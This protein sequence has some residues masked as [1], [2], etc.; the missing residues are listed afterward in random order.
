MAKLFSFA[1][2]N[3]EHFNGNTN[4]VKR[5]VTF[6]KDAGPDVFAIFEVEGKYV[7][8]DFVTQMPAY[9]FFITEDRSR[10]ETLIG[11]RG[12]KTAFVTQ[13]QVFKSSIP[14]LRPGALASLRI[15]NTNYAV[16]FLHIK[17]S[18]EPRS[19]GLR[20]D[21]MGHVINLKKALDKKD[22]TAQGANFLCLGDLNT[23]GMNLTYSDNDVSGAEELARY[24]KRLAKRNLRL[25]KKT[26]GATWWGGTAT[27]AP[28]N[29]DHVFASTHLK[30]KQF[31]GADVAV[32][33]WPEKSTDAQKKTWISKYSDHA[34]IYGEVH[35]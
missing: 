7:Y 21:M 31:S 32:L 30:F 20:D 19:W 24:E 3:V 13:R 6:L 10:M 9:N 27:Y 8:D 26:H 33:G 2:W 4:R 29:L 1:S 14:T 5:I 35:S 16:L 18:P 11:V 15:N 12:N 34:L 23:M 17:S 22:G 28:S 25:L